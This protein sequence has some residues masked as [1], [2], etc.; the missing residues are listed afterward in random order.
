MLIQSH[1]GSLELL[2]A[3]PAAWPEGE[4]TGLRARGGFE[5]DIAWRG[6]ELHR[7]TVT[8]LN[9]NPLVLRYRKQ[10]AEVSSSQGSRHQF[11][12]ALQC[13]GDGTG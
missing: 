8:S 10:T 1:A 5:V 2:P 13:R 9:G 6:G 7:A 11:D 12:A 4:V 3:L